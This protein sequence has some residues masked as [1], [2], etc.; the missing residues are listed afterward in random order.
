MLCLTWFSSSS[1]FK[2]QKTAFF[3]FCEKLHQNSLWAPF[4][5]QCSQFISTVFQT[6]WTMW[7]VRYS[8]CVSPPPP[9]SQIRLR[10]ALLSLHQYCPSFTGNSNLLTL[11]MN[12]DTAQRISAC[13]DMAGWSWTVHL[14]MPFAHSVRASHEPFEGTEGFENHCGK[15]GVDNKLF[16]FVC[17]WPQ[18]TRC[19]S[20]WCHWCFEHVEDWNTTLGCLSFSSQLQTS[21]F[22]RLHGFRSCRPGLP[23]KEKKRS[24]SDVTEKKPQQCALLSAPQRGVQQ[25]S[26]STELFCVILLCRLCLFFSLQD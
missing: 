7:G 22:T 17:R 16:S 5:P 23:E 24:L 2:Q 6:S 14:T 12:M 19:H 18:N 1:Q 11:V 26:T 21:H 8:I 10:F 25:Q 15:R 4:I 9:V 3:L 20:V 13:V